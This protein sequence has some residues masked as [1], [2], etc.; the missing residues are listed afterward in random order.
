MLLGG[1][2]LIDV[3][4]PLY[5]VIGLSI[6]FMPNEAERTA[7]HARHYCFRALRNIAESK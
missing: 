6:A 7:N 5:L 2:A 1:A 3:A 4:A